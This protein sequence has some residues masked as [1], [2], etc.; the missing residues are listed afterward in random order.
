L[1]NRWLSAPPDDFAPNVVISGP[2]TNSWYGTDQL[3]TFTITGGTM[4]IAGYT[5]QWDHDPGA[6]YTPPNDPALLTSRTGDPFW[7]G[8]A[9]PFGTSGSLSLKAA[10]PGC[11]TA[12]VRA[13]NNLG[14]VSISPPYGPICFGEP[15]KCSISFSCLVNDD[16]PP[17]YT[18]QCEHPESFYLQWEDGFQQS[19]GTNT[20]VTGTSDL[21]NDVVLACDSGTNNCARF[22]IFVSQAQWCRPLN[23]PTPHK[24]PNC[25]ACIEAGGTCGPNGCAIKQQ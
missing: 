17:E 9:V 22:S 19:L 10:G 11:H 25:R 8:P 4:G 3:V 12:F 24:P 13:W 7:D 23:P 15:P 2:P 21:Y 18:V 6:G 5:A 1:L 14:S 16:N 20:T